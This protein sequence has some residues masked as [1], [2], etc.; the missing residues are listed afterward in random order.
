MPDNAAVIRSAIA[1]LDSARAKLASIA[2]VPPA[3]TP[4]LFR[5]RVLVPVLN[6]RSGP[7]ATFPDV[8]DVLKD[9]VIDV[10]AVAQPSGWYRVSATEER[11]ISGSGAYTVKV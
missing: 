4:P 8:G 1:D 5:V 7:A 10:Y 11:Y 6:V 9:Q 2:P 3:P